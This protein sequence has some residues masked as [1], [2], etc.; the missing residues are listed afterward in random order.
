MTVER[1][2]A[3]VSVNEPLTEGR[4]TYIV[5]GVMRGGTSMVAGVMRGLGIDLGPQ[6]SEQN[7]E[8]ALLT[9]KNSIEDIRL[10]ISQYSSE[11]DIWGWKFPH[12]ADYLEQVLD[13]ISNPHFICVF[14]DAAANAGGLNRW[15]DSPDTLRAMDA[16][17][18][19]QKKNL[20]LVRK[21]ECPSLLISY[22]KA[23]RHKALFVD[24]FSAWLGINADHNVFD[25]EGFM[26]AESYKDISDYQR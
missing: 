18:N 15:G 6:V 1:N 19:R 16:T 22:E 20:Q 4:R 12:A 25:F 26:A 14:R 17:L 5:M 21:L 7:H 11:K 23:L 24:Q 10:T 3:V 8:S 9:S 2:R 13:E